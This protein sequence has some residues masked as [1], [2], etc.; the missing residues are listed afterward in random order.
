MKIDRQTSPIA[1]SVKLTVGVIL[2]ITFN[3]E[4]NYFAWAQDPVFTLVA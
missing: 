4:Q 3:V 1:L 2:L